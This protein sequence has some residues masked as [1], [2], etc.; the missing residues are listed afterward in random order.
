MVRIIKAHA[1]GTGRTLARCPSSGTAVQW[2]DGP[3]G[4]MVRCPTC[5]RIVATRSEGEAQKV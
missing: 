1:T 5:K 4:I 3:N 2:Q